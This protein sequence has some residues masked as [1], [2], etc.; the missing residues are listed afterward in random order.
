MKILKEWHSKHE[1]NIA[2]VFC[3]FTFI[4]IIITGIVAFISHGEALEGMFISDK[5]D[6]GMDFFHSI[7]YTRGGKPYECWKT[8]YPPLANLFFYFLYCLVPKSVSEKWADSFQ[9]SLNARGTENDLRVTQSTAILYTIFIIVTVILIIGLVQKYLGYSAR[10]F[11]VAI[12]ILFSYGMCYAYERGNIIIISFI[13]SMF[14]VCFKDSSN[15]VVSELALISLAV[16]AGLKLYPAFFGFLL[17]YDKQYA[18]AMRTIVYGIFFFIAPVF[19]FQ[20][21]LHGIKIFFEVLSSFKRAD[22]LE[23]ATGGFSLTQIMSSVILLIQS[24][25][26]ISVNDEFWL[27]ILPKVSLAFTVT[28]LMCGYK[29]KK[30]WMRILVCSTAILV[31]SYQ[32]YYILIFLLIPLLVMMKEEKCLQKSNMIPFAIFIL[33]QVTVPISGGLTHFWTLEDIRIQIC[34]VAFIIYIL[35]KVNIKNYIHE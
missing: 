22:I 6:T 3:I 34:L 23:D 4:S 11:C 31:Y 21:N 35:Q 5:L 25:T 16:A 30:N 17:L 29:I 15:K 7:E 32:S 9:E 18:K 33:S 14:F 13:C 8:L 2:S 24:T 1:L 26:G 20:E 27:S 10:S 12:A 19:C 28:L